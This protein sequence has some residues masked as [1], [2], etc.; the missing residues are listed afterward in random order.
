MRITQAK[1]SGSIGF[2]DI[3]LKKYGFVNYFDRNKP[4]IFFGCYNKTD[5]AYISRHKSLA[6][7][8]W[9][10]TDATK[11]HTK[12]FIP[13]RKNKNL[14]HIV[15]SNFLA[16]DLDN[17]GI[18]YTLLPVSATDVDKFNPVPLGKNI[19][20]YG[21]NYKPEV[22]NKK[23]VCLVQKKINSIF[24]DIDFVYG[25]F[26]LD[27]SLI[28]KYP[29]S[30]HS[31]SSMPEIYSKCFM[32]LRLTKHD[33]LSNTV[34]EM[35]LMGRRCVW[36]GGTPSGIPWGTID[37]IINAVVEEKKLIGVTNL[38]LHEDVKK[39]LD[40]GDNWKDTDF[41]G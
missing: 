40:I 41:Y 14:K 9:R 31:K 24:N 21:V 38:K 39:Y 2:K 3:L 37:D 15:I 7:I 8:I 18:P 12:E 11:L 29:N 20:I 33:G 26:S 13:I 32:G 27:K 4:V 28:K 5:L 23:L 16:K 36:N 34:L 35:G 22:Y 1:V 17:F 25:H 10:G 6:I 30:I 19:Y